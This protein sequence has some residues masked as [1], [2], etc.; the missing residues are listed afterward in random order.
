MTASENLLTTE[1]PDREPLTPA[2]LRVLVENHR[3]FL[4]FLEKRVGSREEAEDILQEA[5]VRGLA[6]FDDLRDESSVIAWFY[7]AL[8]NAVIDHYRSRGAEARALELFAKEVSV[9]SSGLTDSEM[10]DEVCACA[11]SLMSTLKPEYQS[12]L[13]RVDLDGV[14]VKAYAAEEKITASNAGVRLFRAR[15]ALRRQLIRCCGTC[16]DH[17]CLDCSCAG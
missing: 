13:R 2:A 1:P 5:F 16:S 9:T 8:R 15:D 6:K 3:R 10:F 14:A 12:A 17:G 4:N 7:R 11:T